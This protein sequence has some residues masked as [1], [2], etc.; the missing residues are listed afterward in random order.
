MLNL[1]S[2]HM[3]EWLKWPRPMS[4]PAMNINSINKLTQAPVSGYQNPLIQTNA[5]R[6]S[7]QK[8]GHVANVGGA[9]HRDSALLT[10]R[11]APAVG[12]KVTGHRCVGPGGT[13]PLD[14]HH[15]HT[16]PTDREDHPAASHSSSR[17]EEEARAVASSS[18]REAHLAKPRKATLPRRLTRSNW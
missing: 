11:R 8:L 16:L 14:V 17:A 6:K 2:S 7:F 3:T 9:I 15:H 1:R 18:R 10:V 13:H 5:L 12:R 4:G